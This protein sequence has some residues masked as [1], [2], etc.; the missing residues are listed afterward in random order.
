MTK[1]KSQQIM[2][3]DITGL[4]ERMVKLYVDI[5]HV[6]GILFLHTKSKNLNYITIQKI[7]RRTTSEFKKKLKHV[8][9]KDLSIGITIT[10]V[11]AD[12]EFNQ[13][14]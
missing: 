12:S 8:I 4:K 9:M 2:L 11:F 3:Q 6:N 10:N 13:D 14:I 5:F 7:D 1:D